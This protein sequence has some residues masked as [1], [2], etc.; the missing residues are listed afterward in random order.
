MN[1]FLI[2]LAV[3]ALSM[4]VVISSKSNVLKILFLGLSIVCLFGCTG[5]IHINQPALKA[6]WGAGVALGY[7]FVGRS[8]SKKYPVVA[9]ICGT[10]V[11]MHLVLMASNIFKLVEPLWS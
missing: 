2:F 7:S 6:L 9:I 3:N 1:I 11:V 5:A 10:I 4:W 8:H